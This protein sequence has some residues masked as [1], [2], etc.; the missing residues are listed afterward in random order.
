MS[1]IHLVRIQEIQHLSKTGEVLWSNKDLKNILHLEGEEFI[2]KA[3]FNGGNDPNTFIPDEYY[4]GLDN[5]F[6]LDAEHN[7]DSLV[8]EPTTAGYTRQSLSSTNGFTVI[9][10]TEDVLRAQ[11]IILTFEAIGSSWG[12]VSNLFMTDQPD[13]SGFLICSVATGS[14]FTVDDGESVTMRMTFGLRDCT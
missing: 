12:P 9:E 2:L 8:N 14:T 5:R 10:V 4:F 7:M 1:G 6:S 11:S 13:D 3:L